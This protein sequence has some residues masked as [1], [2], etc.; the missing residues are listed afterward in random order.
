MA[1]IAEGPATPEERVRWMARYGVTDEDLDSDTHRP[2]ETMSGKQRVAHYR[3]V[4]WQ[5]ARDASPEGIAYQAYLE[6]R[7]A[8][9]ARDIEDM[10]Q[11]ERFSPE[12]ERDRFGRI[13]S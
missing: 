5:E 8:L 1:H 4:D 11:R 6:R 13:V 9:T 7:R 10:R 2:F 12:S 3:L